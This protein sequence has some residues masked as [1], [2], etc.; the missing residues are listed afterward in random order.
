MNKHG[1]KYRSK[2]PRHQSAPQESKSRAPV[3]LQT[4]HPDFESATG[5]GHPLSLGVRQCQPTE[6]SIK[7]SIVDS[8]SHADSVIDTSG[9]QFG[10]GSPCGVKGADENGPRR[11][12]LSDLSPR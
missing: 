4:R 3:K 6:V 5:R 12:P 8:K 2:L 10:M 7:E 11:Q 1:D 9:S